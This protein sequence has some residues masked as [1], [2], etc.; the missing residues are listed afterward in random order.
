MKAQKIMPD[1]LAHLFY[2][3][4]QD[5]RIAH[6][7]AAAITLS[8]IDLSIPTPIAGIKPGLANIVVLVCLDRFGWK[9]AAWVALLRIFAVSLLVGSLLSPGFFLALSGGVAS[10]LTLGICSK[11]PKGFMGPLGHSVMAA[12]AHIT[13]QITLV[14]QWLL[15]WQAVSPLFPAFALFAFL[16]GLTN[17]LISLFILHHGETQ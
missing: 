10:L 14:T 3:K 5:R 17:G 16:T 1:S 13:A 4:D 2:I 6:Y 15:D 9:M 12:F 11:I 7:T 8:L